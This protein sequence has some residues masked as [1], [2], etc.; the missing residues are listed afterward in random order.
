MADTPNVPVVTTSPSSIPF[1][2]ARLISLPLAATVLWKSFAAL[3]STILPFVELSALARA[4]E[5]FLPV[6]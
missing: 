4:A 5:I 3:A 6:F 1:A 2:S